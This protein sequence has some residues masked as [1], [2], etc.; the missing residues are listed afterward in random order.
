VMDDQQVF[1]YK[2][3]EL[4]PDSQRQ[5]KDPFVSGDPA[6]ALLPAD[7]AARQPQ[8]GGPPGPI[9]V[10][11]GAFRKFQPREGDTRVG[12][13]ARAVL[14]GDAD[15]LN[16]AHFDQVANRE[17][18][19]DIVRWLTGEEMLIRREGERRQAREAMTVSPAQMNLVIALAIGTPVVVFLIGWV[20]WLTRRS[21]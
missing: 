1:H 19:L 3:V 9:S 8:Q 21:K 15:F 6:L 20:I 11:V 16:D 17:L 12:R 18:A 2:L 4:G 10:A 14:V 5:G 13:E 7:Q